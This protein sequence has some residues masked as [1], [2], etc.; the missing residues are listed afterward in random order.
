MALNSYIK[1]PKVVLTPIY[2]KYVRSAL[3]F[4][5]FDAIQN[6]KFILRDLNLYDNYHKFLV[7]P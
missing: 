2:M 1:Y 6:C 4:L 7:V 3:T 5:Y